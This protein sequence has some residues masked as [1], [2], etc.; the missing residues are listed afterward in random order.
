LRQ[1]LQFR[2]DLGEEGIDQAVNAAEHPRI[3]INQV[4]ASSPKGFSGE[5][6]IR[7][8]TGTPWPEDPN[9]QPV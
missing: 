9:H 8:L 3:E 7:R 1:Q 5:I 6:D 2:R 4:G